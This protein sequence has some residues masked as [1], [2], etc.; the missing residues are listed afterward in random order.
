MTHALLV[1]HHV[2]HDTLLNLRARGSDKHGVHASHLNSRGSEAF[3]T[4]NP[5]LYSVLHNRKRC[6]LH[7]GAYFHSS[8]VCFLLQE[9][10]KRLTW[11]Y[12]SHHLHVVHVA[13]PHVHNTPL[14]C[15]TCRHASCT[16]YPTCMPYMSPC[17]M[18]IIPYLQKAVLTVWNLRKGCHRGSLRTAKFNSMV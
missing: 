11:S 18:Y 7:F 15:R 1:L 9:I 5:F 14:T 10:T 3:L 2:N 16:S 4:N 17:F 8:S 12:M 6:H 13:M